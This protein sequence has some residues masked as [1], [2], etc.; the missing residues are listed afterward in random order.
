MERPDHRDTFRHPDVVA[1]TRAN[2]DYLQRAA[3]SLVHHWLE[4]GKPAANPN[5]QGIAP[6]P[7]MGGAD[8][9]NS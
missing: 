5:A 8:H 2:L 6:V 3:L 9:R 1:H 4:A 7:T